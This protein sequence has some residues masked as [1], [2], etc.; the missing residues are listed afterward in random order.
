MIDELIDLDLICF[1]IKLKIVVL[2]TAIL[3]SGHCSLFSINKEK[4]RDTEAVLFIDDL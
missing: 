2:F 1:R 3:L 4:L